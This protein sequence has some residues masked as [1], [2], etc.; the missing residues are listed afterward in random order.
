[1]YG[2][3]TALERLHSNKQQALAAASFDEFCATQ[4]AK[5]GFRPTQDYAPLWDTLKA[6]PDTYLARPLQ[7]PRAVN[8]SDIFEDIVFVPDD[9]LR[10]RVR[11]GSREWAEKGYRAITDCNAKASVIGGHDRWHTVT[12]D[13]EILTFASNPW[14]AI[15]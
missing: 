7:F 10:A 12:K 6:H 11:A 2:T 14:E 3:T 15:L 13:G 8:L 5:G 1:M 9:T 4:G